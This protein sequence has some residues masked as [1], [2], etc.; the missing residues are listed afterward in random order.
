M[1]VVAE[2][3]HTRAVTDHVGGGA[4]GRGP[5]LG[6]VRHRSAEGEGKVGKRVPEGGSHDTHAVM[7]RVS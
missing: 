4:G 6:R 3:L 5:Y 1:P 2:Q 7:I